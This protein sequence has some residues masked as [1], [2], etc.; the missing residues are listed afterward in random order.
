MLAPR[1]AAGLGIEP[2]L[3]DLDDV[4]QELFVDVPEDARIDLRVVDRPLDRVAGK[5]F[6]Q[7]AKQGVVDLQRRLRPEWG[8]DRTACRRKG[9]W[10]TASAVAPVQPGEI[11]LDVA[12]EAGGRAPLAIVLESLH[13]LLRQKILRQ[14]RRVFRKEN[15]HDAEQQF[16]DRVVDVLLRQAI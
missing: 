13:H 2:P 3:L 10:E 5:P 7:A 14:Q 16:H 8:R 15:E 4:S 9:R 12:V 6:Q 11:L 1:V